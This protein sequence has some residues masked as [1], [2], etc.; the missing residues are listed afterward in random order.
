MIRNPGFSQ[1]ILICLTVWSGI[2]L[3]IGCN[4]SQSPSAKSADE[5]GSDAN[6]QPKSTSDDDS[7]SSG[8]TRGVMPIYDDLEPIVDYRAKWAV[9]IG[10]DQYP[11]GESGLQSLMFAV[12]DAR[13]FRDLLRDEFGFA[14]KRIRYL[15]DSKATTR[16][17][18][19]TFQK[20]LPA[21][22]LNDR[23][24]VIV[25]FSGHGLV[26]HRTKQG[27][28]A[29]IDS[30]CADRDRTCISV[31]WLRDELG[32][33][34]CRHKLVI[35]DSCYSGSLFQNKL[36]T[37]SS[38]KVGEQDGVS[39]L[40]SPN[41]A[42]R[43]TGV[44]GLG[45]R[46]DNI[47]FYYQNPAFYG[48]SAGRFTPVVDG[49]GENRH[50]VFTAALLQVLRERANSPRQDHAFTFRQLAAQVESRV[51]N[52]L[53]SRQIPDWGALAT[54]GG[55]FVFR[56]TV[57]RVT[58]RER[59]S[60]T[61]QFFADALNV[62]RDNLDDA[63][64]RGDRREQIRITQ[65]ARRILDSYLSLSIE[66][67]L[68]P[69]DVYGHVLDWAA[70]IY[71]WDKN[72]RQNRA[73]ERVR[74]IFEEL[75]KS[76]S[77]LAN[78]TL[79]VDGV[80]LPQSWLANYKATHDEVVRLERQLVSIQEGLNDPDSIE[81]VSCGGLKKSLPDDVAFVHFVQYEYRTPNSTR[82]SKH[83]LRL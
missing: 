27:F 80:E 63:L 75:Q 8:R 59:A 67:D 76:V 64:R 3:G 19:E 77:K 65:S 21:Q 30:K 37:S 54:G 83:E 72:L 66:A 44:T 55:D 43:S 48:M 79:T 34:P 10:I 2:I 25:F 74:Q 38:P 40:N 16:A 32:A 45:G 57:R 50:S 14:E 24:A 78:L 73:N 29:A 42:T 71:Q 13:E 70:A 52:K 35:L 4:D 26:D 18:R 6:S 11:G 60:Q 9:V 23:D 82:Q 62:A 5:R 46:E 20:W 31:S 81:F 17:I 56:P 1:L 22:Q 51:A 15:V 41:S 33:L 61:Q 68:S 36:T 28:L 53:G 49:L 69:E 58:P 12:N 7:N 47:T 39:S